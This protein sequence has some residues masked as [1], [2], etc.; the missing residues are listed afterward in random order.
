MAVA[1]VSQDHHH[2]PTKAKIQLMSRPDSVFFTTVCFSLKHVW[3]EQVPTAATDGKQILFNPKFFMSLT[4]EERV[5]LMLHE[6]MHVAYMHCDPARYAQFPNQAK[7]G[8]AA[9]YVI[10]LQLVER[11]FKMPACGLLDRQ[12]A[13]MSWEQVYALLPDCPPD[14]FPKLGKDLLPCEGDPEQ[15]VRDIQDI[16]VRASIQSKMDGDKPGTIPGDIEIFLN[17]LLNPKLPWNR[18]LQRYMDTFSKDDYSFRKPNRR[19]FPKFHMP[20]LYSERLMNLAI[21]V[22]TSG[23]VSDSDFQAFVTEVASILRMMKPE[24]ITLLQFDTAIKSVDEL[25]GIQDLMHC[26]FTGRGGTLINP[27]LEW[28]NEHKPQLLMVFSDGE[29]NFSSTTTKSQTL[30]IVHNNAGFNAPFG[31]TI[32]YTI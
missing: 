22:D 28:A 16:L 20:C 7:A 27:V 3:S 31:K 15:L 24:K 6:T 8:K 10:N 32:H 4:A 26:K 17:G 12:Y 23:S 1:V 14:D 2:A 21:A 13:N 5:F 18:I 29:F 25:S 30:W 19:F 9:D 11:G